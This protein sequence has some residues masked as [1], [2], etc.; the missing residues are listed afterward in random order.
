[1]SAFTCT[2]PL[3]VRVVTPLLLLACGTTDPSSGFTISALVNGS[4]W[5][6]V[7]SEPSPPTA[8]LYEGDH[9]LALSGTQAGITPRSRGI[10]IDVRDV[11][12]PGSFPLAAASD[13]QSSATYSETFG[14]LGGGDFNLVFYTT[15][16]TRTG[17]LVI[18]HLDM[19]RQTIS[20]TFSFDAATAQGGVVA[21]TG[22]AF[23]GRFASQP[24]SAAQ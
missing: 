14:T 11:V 16:A 8:I 9:T 24:G 17:T 22:G 13:G 21:I 7:G 19:T 10:G 2:A 6:P 5:A 3:V 12:G 4:S 20:G 18:T 1:M 15:S 23:S